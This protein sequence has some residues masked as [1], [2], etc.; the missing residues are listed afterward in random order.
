MPG[1][2]VGVVGRP[3]DPHHHAGAV[4]PRRD[5]VLDPGDGVG[6]GQLAAVGEHDRAHVVG[7]LVVLD[8]GHELLEHV[9]HG[10]G[11]GIERHDPGDLRPT[12][13]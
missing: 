13:P 11:G 10:L 2:S 9:D 3:V 6:L 7:R 12:A 1:R 8:A 4:G 5:V